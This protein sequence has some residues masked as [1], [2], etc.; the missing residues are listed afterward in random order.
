MLARV[1]R[2]WRIFREPVPLETHRRLELSWARVPRRLRTRQQMLG[3]SSNGCGATIGVMPRCDFR[4]TGCYLSTDANRVPGL[5]L[6]D[7]KRQLDRLRAHLGERGNLQ[8]TDGEVLLRP[9]QEVIEIVRYA[10]GIGLEPM[11]MTHG[12]GLRKRPGLL[13][14]LMIEAGLEEVGIHVDTTQR[15]RAGSAYR[16]ATDE[17]ELEPLRDE[18]AALLRCARERT[19]RPMRAAA[20]MTITRD[21]LAGVPGVIHWVQRNADVFRMISFQPVAIVGR[22]RRGLGTIRADDLWEKIFEALAPSGYPVDR[23][24]GARMWLGHPDCNQHLVGL[25]SRQHGARPRFHPIRAPDDPVDTEVVDTIL[26]RF[27]RVSFK[28]DG[29]PEKVARIAG[30]AVR[31]PALAATRAGP[32]ARHWLRRFDVERP[33]RFVGRLVTGRASVHQLT[34]VSHHFMSTAEALTPRGRERM[35]LCVFHVPVGNRMISMCEA[36]ALGLREQ[37][38]VELAGHGETPRQRDQVSSTTVRA[39]VHGG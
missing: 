3:R 36:N 12:D 37:L 20:L 29:L 18:F 31:A 34:I 39:V 8:L 16:L 26:D 14:R 6:D 9:E 23:L 4:C 2:L 11:L 21:N 25:V 35:E 27:G 24:R 32:F 10:R 7:V 13:E 28:G 22:T 38:Y 30:L 5:S 15:G 1:A 19:G 17:N 33:W